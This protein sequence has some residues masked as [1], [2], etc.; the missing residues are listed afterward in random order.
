MHRSGCPRSVVPV[1][2]DHNIIAERKA[3]TRAFAGWFGCEERLDDLAAHV[4][5]NPSAVVAH[6]NFYL[7]AEV[8]C[9][10]A[11][12]RFNTVRVWLRGAYA[13]GVEP[14]ADEV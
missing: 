14:V 5:A 12:R 11:Q 3:E 13:R 8:A 9:C 7:L 10:Y 6:A 4:I 1:L 2:L